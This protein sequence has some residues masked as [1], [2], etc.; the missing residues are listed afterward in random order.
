MDRP[1]RRPA[2][3]DTREEGNA[4]LLLLAEMLLERSD[5]LLA[6]LGV[7][8]GSTR[9][10]YSGPCP[11]HNGDNPHAF[12]LY[13]QGDFPGKWACY[14]RACEA[15]F[16][17]T[18][19]GF[20]R[21]VLSGTRYDWQPGLGRRSVAH[22]EAVSFCCDFL[23]VKLE[24]I[25][26][27]AQAVAR[28]RFLSDVR[29]WGCHDARPV[30]AMPRD[31]VRAALLIPA[32]YFLER[33]Y[34]PETLDRF[35]VGLC[36][37]PQRPFFERAVVPVYSQ[38]KAV[39]FTARSIHAE[40]PECG[41]HHGGGCP[42]DDDARRRASKW[43]HLTNFHTGHYLYNLDHARPAAA[44]IK[45]VLLVEG[46]GCLW[47]CVDAG[48]EA[49]VASFGAKLSD[50]QQVLVETLGVREVLVGYDRDQAGEQGFAQVKRLLGRLCKVTRLLPPG[51][52]WGGSS[53]ESVRDL[54]A[55]HSL[56]RC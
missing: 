46:P 24:G 33:G 43:L 56:T 21:A 27:D 22:N 47:R 11:V 29:S 7:R 44:A 20:V 19:I 2:R 48:C 15:H 4:R 37:N 18:I 50:A 8:L 35:D 36:T 26:V 10:A 30:K 3:P 14:T 6:E 1:P 28:L 40:C 25:T 12:C 16:P 53:L 49:V 9:R 13:R 34:S 31:S 42:Q 23:G 39:G 52:D 45:K 5:D 32:P 55:A 51:H 17:K 54:L 38:G 41:L